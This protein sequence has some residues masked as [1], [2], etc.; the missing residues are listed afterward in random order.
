MLT[1]MFRDGNHRHANSDNYSRY[2]FN[3]RVGGKGNQSNAE[4]TD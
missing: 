2:D 4:Q 1:E 3:D